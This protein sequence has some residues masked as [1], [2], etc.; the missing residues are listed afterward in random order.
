MGAH[1][2]GFYVD[3]VTNAVTTYVDGVAQGAP[4][5]Q[6]SAAA[7]LVAGKAFFDAQAAAIPLVKGQPTPVFQGT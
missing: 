1:P 3:P 2:F 4:Q 7:A 6:V 5:P